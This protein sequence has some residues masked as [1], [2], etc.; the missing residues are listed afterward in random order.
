M[1]SRGACLDTATALR[2]QMY[3]VAPV[4]YRVILEPGIGQFREL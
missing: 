1:E 4:A 2:V 3:P